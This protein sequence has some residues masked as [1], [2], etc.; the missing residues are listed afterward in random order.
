M[1]LLVLFGTALPEH[2]LNPAIGAMVAVA[3]VPLFGIAEFRRLWS[4]DRG[5][6]AVGAVCFLGAVFLGPIAGIAVAFILSLIL[7]AGRAASR[8]PQPCRH[9]ERRPHPG[10]RHE[11]NH[12]ARPGHPPLRRTNLLRQQHRA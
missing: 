11:A 3:V 8:R 10:H 12:R 9:R 5:E 6:F 4:Q 7:L 1:L 2:I